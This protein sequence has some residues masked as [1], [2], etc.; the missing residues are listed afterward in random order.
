MLQIM[1]KCS[2]I[3]HEFLR[4]SSQETNSGTSQGAHLEKLGLEFSKGRAV[5]NHPV[6]ERIPLTREKRVWMVSAILLLKLLA[7]FSSGEF[8]A[9]ASV[10]Q[11][12]HQT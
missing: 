2:K 9:S 5:K 3:E 10:K 1:W 6:S 4:H 12:P 8:F 7:V 11:V